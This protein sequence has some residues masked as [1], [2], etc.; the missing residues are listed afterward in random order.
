MGTDPGIELIEAMFDE[1]TPV[2]TEAIAFARTLFE[3]SDRGC[4]LVGTAYLDDEIE[5]LLREA[6]GASDDTVK[7][8]VDPLLK[9]GNAPLGSFWARIKIALAMGLI[10]TD[11]HDALDKMRELR[12][13]FAHKTGT[14]SLSDEKVAPIL[15]SLTS[16]V[17]KIV[18]AFKLLI[19][20]Y[21]SEARAATE[22][23]GKTLSIPAGMSPSR[24]QFV[25]AVAFLDREILISRSKAR[26]NKKSTQQHD[27]PDKSG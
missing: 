15:S 17:Q 14:V 2:D 26:A 8:A 11:V 9:G 13:A 4:V 27:N 7:K 5:L 25:L 1:S 19:E 6:F 18:K 3:E 12:N 16:H 24:I 10:N 20:K 22:S 23:H 21:V